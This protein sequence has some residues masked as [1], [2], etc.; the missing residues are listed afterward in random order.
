MNDR[1]WIMLKT[2]SEERNITRTAER[3]YISQPAITYRLRMLEEEFRTK[4]VV[5]TPGGV[6]LTAQG[7]Y[8]LGYAN[9]MLLRLTQTKE[10]LAS[11]EGKVKGPLRVGSSAIFAN[12]E[13]PQLLRGFLEIYPEVEIFLKTG[14]SLQVN[15][16]LEREEVSVAIIRGEYDGN[17]EKR[18]I[19]EDPVCLVSKKPMEI[20]ELP[21]R[22]RIVYGT[23]TSLQEMVD[24][25]WRK[26]F[27]RPFLER[28]AVDNMDTCRRMVLQDL[29][30]AIL[31]SIGLSE[32]DALH[33]Q[34]LSW[35]N[36]DPL[37]R[38]TWIC[39]G[40]YAGKLPAVHAFV[41]YVTEE[42]SRRRA[43]REFASTA[44]KQ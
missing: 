40:S 27:A 38:R 1:D 30:Y 4:I 22:P 13:L 32:F 26:T 9:E 5:R 19:L 44:P 29:G 24:A 14:R 37:V 41:E 2:I 8:L 34:P 12:Y 43:L 23:D 20:Q 6:A 17:E 31:P 18:L 11:F 28:M 16:M 36:G 33:T 25:W 7:E 15:R 35:R 21:D 42:F 3:L 10:R 39:S